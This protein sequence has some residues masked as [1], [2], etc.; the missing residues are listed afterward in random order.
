MTIN[1]GVIG[2]LGPSLEPIGRSCHINDTVLG[3]LILQN[4]IC[5]FVGNLIWCAYANR[6]Q[7]PDGGMGR[8]HSVFAGLM[9]VTSSAAIALGTAE[10]KATVQV[11]LIAWGIAYGI[12]DAGVTSLTV[13]RWAH[14]DRRRRIHLAVLNAGFTVGALVGPA[15]VAI[16]LR[17]GGGRWA[18]HFIAFVAVLACALLGWQP[19]LALPVTPREKQGRSDVSSPPIAHRPSPIAH[20][21]S[22]IAH[23]PSLPA[24]A[25]AAERCRPVA[26]L[27]ARCSRPA[28]CCRSTSPRQAPRG[29]AC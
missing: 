17:Y 15:I 21:P 13:W 24:T 4:R 1:G 5:K 18:F 2:A 23:R 22:P 20:R 25:A 9:L 26:V 27:A 10:K 6:L 14:D 11:A 29:D 28:P 19:G 7:R 16:S 12:T 3:Q 8:P